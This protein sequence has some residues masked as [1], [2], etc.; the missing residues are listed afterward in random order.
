MTG[1]GLGEIIE[2]KDLI[3]GDQKSYISN[4]C[5]PVKLTL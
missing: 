1:L 4:H 3:F 5:C 2:A